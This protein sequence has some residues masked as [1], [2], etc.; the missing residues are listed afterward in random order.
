MIIGDPRTV[1]TPA[2]WAS[3]A[4]VLEMF[5][6]QYYT[7]EDVGTSTADMDALRALTPYVL[8]VSPHLG[9]CG[10]PSP[11]T[12]HGVVAAMRAGWGA[13]SGAASLA[14]ARISIQGA[15]GKVGSCVARLAAAETLD[16]ANAEPGTVVMILVQGGVGLETD[17]GDFSAIP[18]VITAA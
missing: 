11:Y 14:G 17:P 10:D 5:E 7:A 9:G 8:G 16:L 13:T 3:F 18:L 6:G 12:A 15:A 1:K 2:L 4:R